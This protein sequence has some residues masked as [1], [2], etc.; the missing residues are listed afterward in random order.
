VRPVGQRGNVPKDQRWAG[1]ETCTISVLC[2]KVHYASKLRQIRNLGT[3]TK[4]RSPKHAFEMTVERV[5]Q[6]LKTRSC[7]VGIA[8]LADYSF[9]RRN[10]SAPLVPPKPK[11]FDMAYSKLTLRA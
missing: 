11:E 3:S 6:V 5:L 9:Q 4:G 2:E 7:F 1:C 10:N 8:R